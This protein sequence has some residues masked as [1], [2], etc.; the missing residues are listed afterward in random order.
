MN[1]NLNDLNLKKIINN[2]PLKIQLK[3]TT[4]SAAVNND[5][6]GVSAGTQKLKHNF[7]YSKEFLQKVRNERS[8]FIEQIY[9]DIFKAYCYCMNGRYWNPEK[10]FDVVQY[11]F[12]SELDKIKKN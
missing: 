4:D 6:S 12:P 8:K 10:Y 5:T 11:N 9:P 3:T 2:L 7:I 1:A